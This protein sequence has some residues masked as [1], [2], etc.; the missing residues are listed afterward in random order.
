MG[1]TRQTAHGPWGDMHGR[2]VFVGKATPSGGSVSQILTI[3]GVTAKPFHAC[4]LRMRS[5]SAS[6]RT[7]GRAHAPTRCAN[8]GAR[9]GGAP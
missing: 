7:I 8:R 1:Q 3:G 4:A 6:E 2:A 9:A 5:S